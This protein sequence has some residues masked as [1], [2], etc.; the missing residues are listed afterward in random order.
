MCHYS[1]LFPLYNNNYSFAYNLFFQATLILY[2]SHPTIRYSAYNPFIGA[3]LNSLDFHESILK[4]TTCLNKRLNEF[5][6]TRIDLQT[7]NLS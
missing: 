1:T 6:F 2:T 4:Q 5:L 7:N 3:N